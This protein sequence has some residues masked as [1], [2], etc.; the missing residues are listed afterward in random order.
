[1]TGEAA[2]TRGGAAPPRLS[3][4]DLGEDLS[5]LK[6]EE[7]KRPGLGLFLLRADEVTQGF[8]KGTSFNIN[9]APECAPSPKSR[10]T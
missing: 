8:S 7:A 9:N 1:M 5:V 2:E 3:S 6:R 4:K 10:R